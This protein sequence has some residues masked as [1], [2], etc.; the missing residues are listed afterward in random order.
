MAVGVN[1]KTLRSLKNNLCNKKSIV[2][3][4]FILFCFCHLMQAPHSC[5]GETGLFFIA[6]YFNWKEFVND[7]RLLKESGP[8]F[9]I[10]WNYRA[11][12]FDGHLILRPRIE[13]IA[14]RADYDGATQSDI[15]VNTD[16][17][18]YDG[19]AEFHI[20]WQTRLS[21]ALSVEP[22][23]GA[24]LRGWYRKIHGA[25]ASDG[26][27]H[28]AGYPEEWYSLYLKTGL[29]G[30]FSLN[31][32]HRLFVET[33]GKFPVYNESKALFSKSDL[34]PDVTFTPGNAPSWFV[35]AGLQYKSFKSSIYYDGMRFSKSD[36]ECSQGMRYYQPGTK[37]DMYG[38]RI[39]VIF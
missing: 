13:M 39:G 5:A 6:E 11:E 23:A 17:D 18:Y 25:T 33:G 16:T 27:T 35:E 9:G 32:K 34:G 12:F 36:I 7:H 3:L 31:K 22:F 14:G 4:C 37:A 21:A 1:L 2:S 26:S 29:R 28:A 8:R 10:G 19:K 38:M 20:G 30:D 24:G 15:R